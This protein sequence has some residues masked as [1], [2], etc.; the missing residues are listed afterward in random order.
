LAEKATLSAKVKSLEEK[1]KTQTKDESPKQ[2]I[3]ENGQDR[4]L[5]Q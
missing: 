1:L 3:K 5:L 2:E 4:Q